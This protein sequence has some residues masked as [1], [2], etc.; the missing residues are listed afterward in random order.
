MRMR[1][2]MTPP[3]LTVLLVFFAGAT[4]VVGGSTP[5]RRLRFKGAQL[6]E[7][8]APGKPVLLR[9][10]NLDFKLGSDYPY[11]IEQDRAL[12]SLLPGTNLVRLVMN[13]WQDSEGEG[14]CATD[15]PPYY[16]TQQCLEQ[17]DRVLAWST[18]ELG[19]WS[20]ITARSALAAG[21]GGPGRTIFTNA[22]LKDQWLA[23]WGGLA[24]ESAVFRSRRWARRGGGVG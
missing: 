15:V 9:G 21:D 13:H 17:F 5:P 14:D 18:G 8:E 1:M 22:T 6:S 24:R 2:M 10:F 20:V 3:P 11:P 4:A 16:T 12:K 7:P 19:A 23:M